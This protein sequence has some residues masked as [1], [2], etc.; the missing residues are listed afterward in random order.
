M[1]NKKYTLVS[2]KKI[3]EIGERTK[4][5]KNIIGVCAEFHVVN[6]MLMAGC[7]LENIRLTYTVRCKNGIW[8][9]LP[10]CA[11]CM[12]LFKDLIN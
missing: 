2:D 9:I 5:C 6:K 12:I 7:K 8:Q 4:H 3:G 11:N 1:C 10:Y